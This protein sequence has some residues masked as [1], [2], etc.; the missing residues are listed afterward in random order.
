VQLDLIQ[1]LMSVN[2]SLVSIKKFENEVKQKRNTKEDI[3]YGTYIKNG[4][5]YTSKDIIKGY[6]SDEFFEGLKK[7]EE[8][9]SD[10]ENI[11]SD[12]ETD[13]VS[14]QEL[15]SHPNVSWIR[16]SKEKPT[17]LKLSY[18]SGENRPHKWIDAGYRLIPNQFTAG[19]FG[20]AKSGGRKLEIDTNDKSTASKPAEEETVDLEDL[21]V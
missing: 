4:I 18:V 8:Y 11:V 3:R 5:E 9:Y 1:N 15:E 6:Y 19:N 21:L 17:D 7:L 16:S 12:A 20:Q 14:K 13:G 10:L 2:K